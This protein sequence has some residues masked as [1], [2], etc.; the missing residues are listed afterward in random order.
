MILH[1]HNKINLTVSIELWKMENITAIVTFIL[2]L[3]VSINLNSR[4]AWSVKSN[5]FLFRLYQTHS[6]TTILDYE[7]ELSMLWISVSVEILYRE[8]HYDLCHFNDGEAEKGL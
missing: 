6:A 8:I 2:S 3:T 4:L 5:H 7:V 1:V